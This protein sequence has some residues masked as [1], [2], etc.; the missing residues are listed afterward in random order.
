[1]AIMKKTELVLEKRFD[2]KT[3][4]HTLNGQ[5]VVLHCHHYA[6]LYLQLAE[7]CGML[8]GK[9]LMHES[10][11]DAFLDVLN[12]YND[13]NCIDKLEDRIS[14][15][16][17]YFAACGLGKLK[18]LCAGPDSG[19]VVLEHSHVDEGWIKKWGKR[20][21]AINFIAS[22]YIA[23]LFSAT[24]EKRAR[25]Y[26]VNEIASIVTGDEVSKFEVVAR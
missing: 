16:E 12:S 11:E 21:K 20:K 22:G 5:E 25:T 1:M 26:S 17:Q 19:E 10:A 8:D 2:P 15:A 3:C 23:A 7:D 13:Q 14:I 24:F 18:V 4:R 9:K 6:T